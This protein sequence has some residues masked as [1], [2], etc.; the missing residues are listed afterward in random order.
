MTDRNILIIKNSWSHLIRQSDEAGSLFY[1]RLFELD[2]ELKAM[3]PADME[4]QAKKLMDMITFMVT[5]LQSMSGIKQDIES[6]AVRH[7]GYGTRPQHYI[8]VGSALIWVLEQSLGDLW[9][10]ETI[11]AWTSLYTMWSTAMIHAAEHGGE[12]KRGV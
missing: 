12:T 11:Q 9:N 1:D 7:A 3:F 5:N 2:P 10:Q 6:L 8:T 4:A